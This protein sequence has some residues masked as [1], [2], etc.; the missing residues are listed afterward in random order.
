M[1]ENPPTD[2]PVEPV[3]PQAR[4]AVDSDPQP[5]PQK[6]A[7]KPTKRA[8][9]AKAAKSAAESAGGDASDRAAA[10]PPRKR[11][12]RSRAAK[13]PA[14]SPP[15][16]PAT[17]PE[18]PPVA[19]GPAP[20]PEEPAL[21][22]QPAAAGQPSSVSSRGPAAPGA[23]AAAIW[24]AWLRATYPDAPAGGIARLATRQAARYGWALTALELGGPVAA[25]VQLSALAWV[26]ATLALRIAAAYGHDPTDPRRAD[27]LLELL[28]LTPAADEPSA[29]AAP[30]GG[31]QAPDPG[32]PLR[33][34][35]RRLGA[36]LYLV[37]RLRPRRR[38][39]PASR[40]VRTYLSASEQND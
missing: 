5:R 7:T 34:V 9:R 8:P 39:N 20:A 6:R 15:T 27:E 16:T 26:R 32:E 14:T 11:A 1:A 21:P 24:D 10:D 12:T 22:A 35:S 17:A 29:E 37:G 28:Q 40:A 2:P 25:P 38:G 33:T 30:E 13:R 23:W 36:G 18:P 3:V 19:T 4:S 31:P